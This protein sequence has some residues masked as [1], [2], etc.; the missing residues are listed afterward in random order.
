MREHV[1]ARRERLK[2]C[3]GRARAGG[4]CGRAGTALERADSLLQRLAIRI[5]VA[6]IHES[7]RV[8]AFH[9]ALERGGK[10]NGR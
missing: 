1:I 7:A 2:N 9:V 10:V 4:K 3:A 8:G 6:R 5:V